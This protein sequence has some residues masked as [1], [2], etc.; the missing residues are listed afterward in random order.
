M[1]VHFLEQNRRFCYI[2]SLQCRRF[3]RARA[4]SFNRESAMFLIFIK[5]RK[6]DGSSLFGKYGKLSVPLLIKLQLYRICCG[7]RACSQSQS[8]G[9]VGGFSDVIYNFLFLSN[10]REGSGLSL[11]CK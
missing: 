5:L 3:H 9:G 1:D 7:E 8:K 6:S 11:D 10:T 2:F 4:N